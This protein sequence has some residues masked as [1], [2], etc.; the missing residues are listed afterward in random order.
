MSGTHMKI[1]PAVF[2]RHSAHILSLLND[3]VLHTTWVYD[4]DPHPESY[5]RE[6]FEE[7]EAGNYPVLAAES[8]DGTFLG[9]ASC[10]PYRHYQGYLHAAELSVYVEPSARRTGVGTA[11]LA[12]LEDECRARGIHTL[13]GVIDSENLPSIELHRKCGYEYAGTVREAGRKFGRWLTIVYYQK[14]L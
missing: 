3:A 9:F 8:D 5:M 7:H 11:L 6:Y 10:G 13:I 4:C 1:V 12:R 14:L 2:E